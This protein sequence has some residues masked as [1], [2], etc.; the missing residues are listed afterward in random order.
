MQATELPV[1]N[2]TSDTVYQNLQNEPINVT[3]SE[4]ASLL[5]AGSDVT[6]T[7][8]ITPNAFT[9]QNATTIYLG[10]GGTAEGN[11]N[12]VVLPG[13]NA[14]FAERSTCRDHHSRGQHRG[15]PQ[16]QCHAAGR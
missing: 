1:T 2:F 9:Q 5:S 4:S 7:A 14:S 10:F 15:R 13:K 3:L 6:I 12:Y 8:T 16:R 11:V